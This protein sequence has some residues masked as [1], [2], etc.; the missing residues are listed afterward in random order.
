MIK[1]RNDLIKYLEKNGLVCSIL[2]TSLIC[3]AKS[4]EDM[5]SGM[6]INYNIFTKQFF[7]HSSGIF[8]DQSSEF[9]IKLSFISNLINKFVNK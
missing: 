4:D 7:I 3:I 6:C 1:Y 8:I 5:V 2:D 9:F